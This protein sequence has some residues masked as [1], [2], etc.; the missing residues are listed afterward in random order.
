MP[1]KEP[2]EGSAEQ[3]PYIG[4]GGSDDGQYQN[5]TE[6]DQRRRINRQNIKGHGSNGINVNLWIHKL[7]DHSG[8][9]AGFFSSFCFQIS[10]TFPY[11]PGK[12]EHIYGAQH[13][14]ED[15][16]FWKKIV[17]GGAEKSA[18]AHDK[19]ETGGNPKIKDNTAAESQSGCVA[20]RKQ[21]VGSWSIDSKK[22][23]N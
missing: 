8:H 9:K 10:R 4:T 17:Q 23:V 6:K 18:E 22:T 21:I 12:I 19:E 7:Q 2:A 5:K 14:H 11:F 1:G 15:F 3:S 13:L 20:H 16:Y